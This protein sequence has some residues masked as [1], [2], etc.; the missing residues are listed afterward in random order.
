MSGAL[1]KQRLRKIQPA[2]GNI[3]CRGI[4]TGENRAVTGLIISYVPQDTSFLQGSLDDYIAREKVDA[5]LFWQF[6]RKLD[7]SR[8]HFE[9]RMEEF[10]AGQ[11]KKLLL[12]KSLCEQA[13][14]YIWDEPLNYI[15]I[16]SRMQL[17][18]LILECRPTMILVEHD[19]SFV[20]RVATDIV[21]F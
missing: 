14:V 3:E 10:S 9:K 8:A 6:L 13:H 11:R 2:E 17:E 1:G 12:A 19:K 20:E 4:W 16:F 15:D 18:E 21:R 7:F 5:A